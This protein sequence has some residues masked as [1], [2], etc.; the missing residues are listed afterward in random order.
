VQLQLLELT[1]IYALIGPQRQH[2]QLDRVRRA[3]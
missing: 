3:L 1:R 2:K